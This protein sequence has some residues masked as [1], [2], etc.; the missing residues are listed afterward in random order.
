M[1]G[2]HGRT[3]AGIWRYFF[4]AITEA[5]GHLR[6]ELPQQGSEEEILR[7]ARREGPT[8]AN[9]FEPQKK[10]TKNIAVVLR[11]RGTCLPLRNDSST[12][13]DA[14]LLKRHPEN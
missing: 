5:M 8:C 6:Q 7:E 11:G 12:K 9:A 13:D 14:A 4:A 3:S 10:N 1:V 2:A